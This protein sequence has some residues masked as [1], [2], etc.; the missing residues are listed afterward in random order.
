MSTTRERLVLDLDFDD[1]NGEAKIRRF[2]RTTDRMT[3]SV[4]DMDRAV[5]RNTRSQKSWLS[6]LR[7]VSVIGASFRYFLPDLIHMTWGWNDAIASTNAELERSV[8]VMSNFSEGATRMEKMKNATDSVNNL[9]QDA[10]QLPFEFNAL[11]DS[12][13]KLNTGVGKDAQLLFDGLTESVSQFGGSSEMLKRASVAVLQMGGKGVVSME[14]LRQQLGEAVPNAAKLMARSLSMTYGDFV[15][16]VSEGK[17]TA[18]TALREMSREMLIDAEGSADALMQTYD[19]LKSQIKTQFTI[20]MKELNQAGYFETLKGEM[21]EL[22]EFLE[23]Q[24]ARDWARTFG[25]ALAGVVGTLSDLVGFFYDNAEIFKGAFFAYAGVKG[26]KALNQSIGN[27]NKTAANSSFI[28]RIQ[29]TIGLYQKKNRVITKF[30]KDFNSYMVRATKSYRQQA[31][32]AGDLTARYRILRKA[33]YQQIESQARQ[34]AA[35][36]RTRNA[37]LSL[38]RS[39]SMLGRAAGSVF[40][41]IF[42][43]AVVGGIMYYV[44]SVINAKRETERMLETLRDVN[45]FVGMGEIQQAEKKLEG[46][47]KDLEDQKE[48]VENAK[49]MW[50]RSDGFSA[51]KAYEDA[52]DELLEIYRKIDQTSALIESRSQE[53]L[54]N[55]VDNNLNSFNRT[56]E[57]STDRIRQKYSKMLRDLNDDFNS[58]D[59]EMTQSDFFE[60]S[61]EIKIKRQAGLVEEYAERMMKYRD[62]FNKGLFGDMSEKEF[63]NTVG[64]MSVHLANMNSEMERLADMDGAPDASISSFSTI[65]GKVSSKVKTVQGHIDELNIKMKSDTPFQAF[66]R[67]LPEDVRNNDKLA[68]SL[69]DLRA[70]YAELKETEKQYATQKGIKAAADLVDTLSV[71]YARMGLKAQNTISNI[72]NEFLSNKNAKAFEA[73]LKKINQRLEQAG[74]TSQLVASNLDG[75]FSKVSSEAQDLGFSLDGLE[76]KLSDVKKMLEQ[77]YSA[78][79]ANS[80]DMITTKNEQLRRKISNVGRESGDAYTNQVEMI[81]RAIQAINAERNAKGQL[82]K[83]QRELMSSLQSTKSLYGD[84]AA[85]EAKEK[86]QINQMIKEWSDFETQIKSAQVNGMDSF[87]DSM[88]NVLSGNSGSWSEWSENILKSINKVI[89][90]MLIMKY[91]IKPMMNAFG[92]GPEQVN[93]NNLTTIDQ[94]VDYV[95]TGSYSGFA[96]GGIMTEFGETPLNKYANGGIANSP[97]MALFGEGRMPEAYVPLPD[98]RTIPVTVTNPDSKRGGGASTASTPVE[99]NVYN[100]GEDKKAESKTRFDGEKMIV[101]VFM[102]N[103]NKPGPMRDAVRSAK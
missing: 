49:K 62:D 39:F 75:S 77:A 59:S 90:K 71:K 70:V 60:K 74:L 22:L 93:G 54:N 79:F 2:Q 67:S 43:G 33:E 10:K 48:A 103:I 28:G 57:L 97:Q 89:A 3:E 23:S 102:K 53:A 12:L 34:A 72:D 96:N 37:S 8:V 11:Q 95:G 101:D 21:N 18:Q 82:T 19:G 61:Q 58:G 14:E 87:A 83:Q 85:A 92:G 40:G 47:K 35:M 29:K 4:Y 5:K 27:V 25:Q 50:E 30:D 15:K 99:V 45:S 73:D 44:E 100:Q 64:A 91:L 16:M 76:L 20:L 38:R 78:D 17:I 26:F 65:V 41:G 81:D 7:D 66:F 98:G 36:K 51:K 55:S 24:E 42:G 56:F 1:N 32:A 88:A 84:L 46:F 6:T 86:D 31:V 69:Q 80:I 9:L 13:V 52:V 63:E 94:N 68:E